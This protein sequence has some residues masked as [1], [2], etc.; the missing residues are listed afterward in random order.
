MGKIRTSEFGSEVKIWLKCLLDK[1]LR[2]CLAT[3]TYNTVLYGDYSEPSQTST[4]GAP[5]QKELTV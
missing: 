5:F 4:R 1:V 3:M 2:K